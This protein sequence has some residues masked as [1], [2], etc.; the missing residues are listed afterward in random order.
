MSGWNQHQLADAATTE[1]LAKMLGGTAEHNTG[2]TSGPFAI[3]DQN[4]INVNGTHMNA[5]LT[6]DRLAGASPEFAAKIIAAMQAPGTA[7][8]N[9]E[10]TPGGSNKVALPGGFAEGG[11]VRGFATGGLGTDPG[12]GTNPGTGFGNSGTAAASFGNGVFNN[13]TPYSGQRILSSDPNADPSSTY[14]WSPRT[15][16][17]YSGMSSMPATLDS[18]GNM[19]GELATAGKY[20]LYGGDTAG[21]IYQNLSNIANQY[22]ASNTP[23]KSQY[24][25][26]SYDPT[27]FSASQVGGTNG[28]GLQLGSAGQVQMDPLS[29]YQQTGPATWTDTGTA[30]AYQDPYMQQVVNVQKQAAQRDYN[31]TQQNRDAAAVKAGAYGGSREGV[32]DSLANRDLQTQLAQI[33]ATG[34]Q[35][36]YQNAQTQFNTD[37]ARAEAAKQAN[38]GAALQTQGLN[39]N[40]QLQ[41]ALA[42]QSTAAN[43]YNTLFQG[44]LQAALANQQ[45]GLTAQ[46]LGEQSRQFGANLGNN[47]AQFADTSQLQAKQASA[48]LQQAALGQGLNATSQMGQQGA[49]YADLYRLANQQQQSN[50]GQM[51]TAGTAQDQ[52]AQSQLN[53]GYQDYVNQQNY[54]FQLANFYSGIMSGTPTA[55]NTNATQVGTSNYNNTAQALGGIAGLA[56]LLKTGG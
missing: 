46:Q 24:Q 47:S 32:A 53:M 54:P 8:V 37:A 23:I 25:Q 56:G 19:Q 36:G 44:Q 38:L 17:A 40:A 41:G 30:S 55:V 10:Q 13:Y 1:Q 5:G 45:A 42:N 33:Q 21:S 3:P 18:N 16:S 39:T 6:Q 43:Q 15:Q 12:V 14:A 51:L 28:A 49:N 4:Y 26:Q 27:Q 31:E 29:M 11:T 50:L 48:Q 2:S 34:S 7:L 35:A 9:Q 20:M 52:L 22:D